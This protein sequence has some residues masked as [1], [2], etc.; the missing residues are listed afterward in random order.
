MRVGHLQ[1]VA[2]D[3]IG[4]GDARFVHQGLA[5]MVQVLAQCCGQIGKLSSGQN[6]F[7]LHRLL[8]AA[9]QR[10]ARVGAADV[11]NQAE[12]GVE[13]EAADMLPP[14]AY[15][16]APQ[17]MRHRPEEFTAPQRPVAGTPSPEALQRLQAAVQRTAP[18]AQP[19]AQQR[20]APQPEPER[21]S[22]FGINSLINRMTGNAAE[23][24]PQPQRQQ[25]AVRAQAAQPQMAPKPRTEPTNEQER[26]EIPAFLRR[27]AN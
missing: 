18:A 17:Q 15:Q 8:V 21:G 22:R 2:G 14:P 12:A 4:N 11:A 23:T 27:Q 26:I 1:P 5:Y 19:V 13:D 10:K 16:P 7:V 9:Q 6:Q 25:P 3:G 20:P 24:A